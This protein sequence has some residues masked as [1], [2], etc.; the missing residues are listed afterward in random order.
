M[1]VDGTHQRVSRSTMADATN[2]TLAMSSVDNDADFGTRSEHGDASFLTS[3]YLGRQPIIDRAGALSGY[4]LLFRQHR[5]GNHATFA[6]ADRA[7]AQV[8]VNTICG[9]GMRGVLGNKSG[10]VNVG[11]GML[12]SEAIEALPAQH[13]VLEILEDVVFNDATIARC[14]ALK[15]AGYRLA[16]DDVTTGRIV[17]D[18][19][20]GIVD[21]VKIDFMSTP[22]DDL[23]AL[24][25]S[26]L[27][28]GATVLAEKV[29][30][31]DDFERAKQLGCALFQGYFFARPEVL[32]ARQRPGS[33]SAL[34]RLINVLNRD[35]NL[36]ELDDALKATPDILIRALQ[37]TN[38]ASCYRTHIPVHSLREAIQRVGTVRLK[39]W[40][41]LLIYAHGSHLPMHANP[42]IQMVGMRARFMELAA[43][44]IASPRHASEDLA[45]R[46][47][48]VGILSLADAALGIDLAQLLH[49]LEV[50]DEIRGAVAHREG[51]LGRLLCYAEAI[52]SLDEDAIDA[53]ANGWPGLNRSASSDLAIRAA[54]W[55]AENSL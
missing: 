28:A 48:L 22:P 43:C 13:F 37:L 9:L 23:P 20:R 35:A 42:L 46:A 54:Q 24:I 33:A 5:E 1:S 6:D 10:F 2:Q 31:A 27:R 45:S 18:A 38:S 52:E 8:I 16:L 12:M 21:I 32:S 50:S 15:A 40:A 25:D 41:Q 53:C 47:Y 44:R 11:K 14:R 17:P 34:I 49:E 51:E 26:Y 29:E 39:R 19:V 30:S 7:T 36:D 55:V 3:I 4:E